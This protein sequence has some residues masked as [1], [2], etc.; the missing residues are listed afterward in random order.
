M[1]ELKKIYRQE[2]FNQGIPGS[3][4]GDIKEIIKKDI[5]KAPYRKGELLSLP[6][7]KKLTYAFTS[8]LREIII[9]RNNWKHFADMFAKDKECTSALFKFFENLRNKYKHPEREKE[10]DETE[11]KLG[12]WGMQWIRR[13]I[14]LDKTDSKK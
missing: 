2:W 13:C 6:P 5:A 3:I 10:M 12:Y 7:E 9:S 11:R 4:Q 1:Q 8:H 14:G